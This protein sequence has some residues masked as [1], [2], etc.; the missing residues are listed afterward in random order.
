[1]LPL[2]AG[3][4]ILAGP[5]DRGA[6]ASQPQAGVWRTRGFDAFRAGTFG[7][8]GQNLYV[9]R[10]GVLQRIHQYDLNRDGWFDLVLCN[11]Q[12]FG[13]QAPAYVYA[14]PLGDHKRVELPSDGSLTGTVSDLNSDGY[15]DFVLGMKDNGIRPDLNAFIYFGGPDGLSERRQ[16]RLP[17]PGCRSVAAGDFNGDGRQDLAFLLADSLRAFYQSELG[18]EPRRFTPVAID[19]CQIA[20]E[21]MD[22]DGF[23]DLVARRQRGDGAIYWGGPR[24]LDVAGALMSAPEQAGADSREEGPRYAESVDPAQPLAKAIRLGAQPHL[25]LPAPRSASLVAVGPGQKLGAPVELGCAQALS[26]AVGDV[27]GDG[28]PD[29]AVAC[30]EPHGDRQRSWIYWGSPG[31]LTAECRTPLA[32]DR[33][34]DVAAGDLDGDGCDEVVFCQSHSAEWFTT[35]SLVFRGAKDRRPATPLELPTEDARRVF[36]AKTSDAGVR[37]VVFVNHFAG[38][39]LGRPDVSIF[40]GGS[41]GYQPQRHSGVAGAGA[42]QGVCCD[43]NDDGWADLTLANCSENAVHL[44]PG[45]YVFFNGAKGFQHEPSLRLPTTR[46]HGCVSAD[47]DRDGYLDLAFCGFDNPELVFFHG[48]E[49]GFDTNRVKRLRLEYQGT[50]YREP[51]WI[52]LADLNADGWLDLV[53]PMILDDRSLILWGAPDG[54]SMDRCLAL[55]VERAACAQA[56]DL[57]GSGGLDLILGGHNPTVGIPHDSF[58]HLYWNGPAGL[59]QDRR[60]MLPSL[61]INSMA[62]ADFNN[63]RQLDVFVSSYHAGTT[64]DCDSLLYWNRKGQGFS[65]ADCARLPTHSASGCVAADFNEDGWTDLAIAN[66]KVW[67]DHRGWSAVWWN[68]PEGFDPRRITRLPSKGP[69]GMTLSPGNQRDRGAEEYYESPPFQLPDGAAARSIRWTADVPP[70]TWVKAQLRFA[71]SQQSLAA[72]A[73]LGPD[74]PNTW[75]TDDKPAVP[76]AQQGRWV[77][78][79]LALGA[80]NG[81]STPRVREVVVEYTAASAAQTAK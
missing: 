7:N 56:A 15:D 38:H 28:H 52:D 18:F 9:S 8:A 54:F 59:R 11:S 24:G 3:V 81:L 58:V 61:G 21:D 75:F 5:V 41:G 53:V 70:K 25:F 35:S 17:A 42:V 55:S 37:Q 43:L 50:E 33:A 49:N 80:A 16:L 46:A 39:I 47:L 60:S 1:M 19:A 20:A 23:A 13:E 45:S 71:D 2:L 27:D 26:A 6:C 63:D 29:L 76:A 31:G 67:G 10:H 78:Y 62:V 4:A 36:V 72:A 65:E 34:C 14:D 57:T 66:H 44:D 64:R 12:D 22:G 32:T 30:R 68:G 79:R 51:R 73:W 48:G 40:W 77:A 69:H 74:G